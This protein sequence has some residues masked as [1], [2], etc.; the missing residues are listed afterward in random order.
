MHLF[1]EGSFLSYFIVLTPGHLFNCL[2]D[3]KLWMVD[4]FLQLIQDKTDALIDSS[5]RQTKCKTANTG[6]KPLS[7]SEKLTCYI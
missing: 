4:N 6:I 7:K 1:P 2:F 3:I 5:E